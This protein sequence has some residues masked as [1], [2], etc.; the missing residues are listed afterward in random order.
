MIARI[1]NMLTRR[2]SRKPINLKELKE[3]DHTNSTRTVV[4]EKV[5]ELDHEQ[6]ANFAKDL[7]QEQDF[8]KDNIGLM[9]MTADYTCHCILLKAIGANDGIL[10]E[11]EGYGYCRY[12]AY[13]DGMEGV[14]DE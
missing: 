2:F 1:E 7:L 11:A 5:I 10:I 6:F 14:I 9:W 4:I 3:V 12:G 13:W 8:I